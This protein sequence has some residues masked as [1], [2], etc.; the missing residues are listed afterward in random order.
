MEVGK[1]GSTERAF[2]EHTHPS[3]PP[4]TQ[5]NVPLLLLGGKNGVLRVVDAASGA[6]AWTG[7]GHGDGIN[8][9]SSCPTRPS[10]AATASR[11]QSVRLWDVASRACVA[12]LLGE[13]SHRSEVLSL[14]WRPPRVDGGGPSTL[15]TAAMDSSIL[16]WDAA[17]SADVARAL[18]EAAAAAD[19]V[20]EAEAAGGG[21]AAARRPQARRA[22]PPLPAYAGDA[23]PAVRPAV[24]SVPVRAVRTLHAGSYVDCVRW[25]GPGG[26]LASKATDDCVLIWAAPDLA[27]GA[28]GCRGAA[29]V[30]AAAPPLVPDV[31]A[32]A[33]A[34]RRAALAAD[35][36]GAAAAAAASSAHPS[37]SPAPPARAPTLQA[38]T[39]V[40]GAGGATR[41]YSLAGSPGNP[42]RRQ[43][44]VPA[45]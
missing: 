2:S 44:V 26:A 3:H 30:L 13:G 5:R 39:R 35:S 34:A 27:A 15:A 42:W 28:D 17:D 38:P 1:S 8:D 20:A 14:S 22:P 37:V 12:V 21:S 6:L 40:G 32:A 36:A 25:L 29:D 9:V 19:A 31:A 7:A 43:R 18:K 23:A 4:R 11:D 16:L 24:I 33:I 45:L 41:G 10:L